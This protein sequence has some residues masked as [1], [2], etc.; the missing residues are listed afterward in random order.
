MLNQ[1][2]SERT[3]RHLLFLTRFQN[4]VAREVVR[5]VRGLLPAII[6]ALERAKPDSVTSARLRLLEQEVRGILA[7]IRADGGIRTRVQQQMLQLA[8]SEAQW[9]A[10]LFGAEL[11]TTLN[12]QTLAP[13]QL[14]Q[15]VLGT[16][17]EGRFFADHLERIADDGADIIMGAVRTGLVQSETVDQ[18]ARRIRGTAAERGRDG[19]YARLIRY[20][21]TWARTTVLH[22][23]NQVRESFMAENADLISGEQY[24][25]TLD[26]RT[27]PTCMGYDGQVFDVGKG[28]VPP[29]HF[30]CRCTRVPVVKS[31]QALGLRGLP[32]STRASMNGQVPE[33]MT[34][35]AWLKTQPRD[36][37]DEA[38][39]RT[40]AELFRNGAPV[41]AFTNQTGRLWTLD[42]LRRREPDI[43]RDL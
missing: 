34:Y 20:S 18:I 38:L 1:R 24:V 7:A 37:Q 2:L 3:I 28:P 30:N 19:A 12:F 26:V 39:G 9:Q 36:V 4:T 31:W 43:F 25:A 32:E 29:V 6:A 22:T 8:A 41:E 13:R 11:P 10:G 42:E 5:E 33:S 17:Y 16:P 21:D 14:E 15:A 40:R 35:G 27:C 23:S